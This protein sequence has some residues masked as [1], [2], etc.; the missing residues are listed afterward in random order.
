MESVAAWESRAG[1]CLPTLHF[2]FLRHAATIRNR[3]CDRAGPEAISQSREA[4]YLL[5]VPEEN[6]SGGWGGGKDGIIAHVWNTRDAAK[7]TWSDSTRELECIVQAL[8]K[9]PEVSGLDKDLN[10]P[11]KVHIAAKVL[12]IT[13]EMWQRICLNSNEYPGG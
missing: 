12:G 2:R 11:P 13:T 8:E 10:S 4:E 9:P 5:R 6:R 3:E 1:R 7:F